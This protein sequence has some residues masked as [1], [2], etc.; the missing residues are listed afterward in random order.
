MAPMRGQGCG[1]SRHE[2]AVDVHHLRMT[3]QMGHPHDGGSAGAA[4]PDH[5]D[6]LHA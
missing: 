5:A 3:V 6:T 4:R 2:T 1:S